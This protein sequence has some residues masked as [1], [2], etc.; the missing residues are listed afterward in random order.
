MG[1]FWRG[2]GAVSGLNF[3]GGMW[4]LVPW[5]GFELGK[6]AWER[7]V[8]ATGSPGKSSEGCV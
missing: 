2:V 8:L 5:P 4:D 7:G 1:F 6:P 3:S